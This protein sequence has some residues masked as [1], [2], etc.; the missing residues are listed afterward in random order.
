LCIENIVV[1]GKG[2]EEEG[3]ENTREFSVFGEEENKTT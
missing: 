3:K 2:H 1:H